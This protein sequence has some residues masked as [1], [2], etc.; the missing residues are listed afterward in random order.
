MRQKEV[1][2]PCHSVSA[3]DFL[4]TA[5]GKK[6]VLTLASTCP[7]GRI[8]LVAQFPLVLDSANPLS[9]VRQQEFLHCL[10]ANLNHPDIE[11]ISI[12]HEFAAARDFLTAL[13]I[14]DPFAKLSHN[15]APLACAKN[16]LNEYVV[17]ISDDLASFY[18]TLSIFA[19]WFRAPPG[20]VNSRAANQSAYPASLL[21]RL[22][23]TM[24][25][26]IEL[27]QHG[28][29]IARRQYEAWQKPVNAS[30]TLSHSGLR[31]VR[32]SSLSRGIL[33]VAVNS[34]DHVKQVCLSVRSLLSQVE[35]GTAPLKLPWSQI[36]AVLK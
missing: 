34:S 36:F 16:N 26:D 1:Q 5:L 14:L 23:D 13:Q 27:F 21:T 9:T 24:A 33:Y 28:V 10:K 32:K 8:H 29:A 30:P 17:G 3:N 6:N 19:P 35:N 31:W 22:S 20:L 4:Q 15:Q 7:S 12:L 11:T 18:E 2:S 25:G